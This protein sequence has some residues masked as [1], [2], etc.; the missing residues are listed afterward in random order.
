MEEEQP[1]SNDRHQYQKPI[2]PI[3]FNLKTIKS[4]CK[5]KITLPVPS[6]AKDA[7]GATNGIKAA[8]IALLN[9]LV[10]FF[11]DCIYIS[12]IRHFK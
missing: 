9:I 7:M 5:N 6:A 8:G 11:M 4:Y 12:C 3:I 10:S 2:L 1:R